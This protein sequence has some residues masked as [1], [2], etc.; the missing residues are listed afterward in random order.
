MIKNISKI[1]FIIF[2]MLGPSLLLSGL[3][4]PHILADEHIRGV[5]FGI[6]APL[7]ILALEI[8]VLGWSECSLRRMIFQNDKSQRIDLVFFVI[9]ITSTMSLLTVIF[10]LGG[11]YLLGQAGQILIHQW[12][13]MNLRIDT[14]SNLLN[15]LIYYIIFSFLAYWSH[16]LFH[17]GPFWNIHRLHHSATSLN[18]L[19]MHRAHPANLFLDPLLRNT[20]PIALV[21]APGPALAALFVANSFHQLLV[22]SSATWD[23]GWFGKWVL[24]S[25]A[26]HKIHHSINPEHYGK[27]LTTDLVIW[28]HLF[29]TWYAGDVPVEEFGITENDYGTSKL[30]HHCIRDLRLFLAALK[31]IG[32]TMRG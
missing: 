1:F 24:L 26:A 31:N 17:T 3:S 21:A 9:H 27:N 29:G 5:L 16:R 10:S 11:S 25:P 2:L 6:G 20:L 28:D 12:T 4:T 30:V 13:G 15:F 18:P 8:V 23:W 32:N 19:V 22:H 14:G 7:L